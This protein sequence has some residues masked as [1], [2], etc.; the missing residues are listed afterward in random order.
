MIRLDDTENMY[1][2]VNEGK[3]NWLTSRDIL[4][5]GSMMT[6]SGKVKLNGGCESG[7]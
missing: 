5:L 4:T 7:S 3:Y 6:R 1:V 2:M